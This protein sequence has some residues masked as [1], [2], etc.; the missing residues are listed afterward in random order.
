MIEIKDKI[1]C[2]GCGACVDICNHNAITWMEDTEGFK[3]PSVNADICTDCGL[4][5]RVCPIIYNGEKNKE[6]SWKKWMK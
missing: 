6:N 2:T 5:N 3:Y 1:D 4:C